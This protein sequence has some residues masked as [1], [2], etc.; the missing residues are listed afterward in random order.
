MHTGVTGEG[1]PL[2]VGP[3]LRAFRKAAATKLGRPIRQQDVAQAL[4]R[5]VRWYQDLESGTITRSFTRQELDIIGSVLGLGRPQRQ[6]LF[7]TSNGGGLFPPTE[8]HRPPRISDELRLLLERQPFPAYVVDA[9]WNVLAVNAAMADLFP[10]STTP[11]ANLLRWLLLHPEARKQH[12]NWSADAEVCVR[13]LRAATVDRPHDRGLRQLI[14]DICQDPAVHDLWVRGTADFAE[15][16]DGHILHMKLPL[17][18]GQVT[19]LVTHVLRPAGLPGCYMTVLARRTP[20]KASDTP[21]KP[22]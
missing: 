13:M 18:G 12:V 20:E 6:A 8:N 19:E 9:T 3:L 22:N 10:W 16:H 21:V 14:T 5:S 17:L 4:S 11:G 7:L 15:H 2:G 1:E